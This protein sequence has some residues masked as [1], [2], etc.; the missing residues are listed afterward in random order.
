MSSATDDSP[1][2]SRLNFL[3]NKL[4]SYAEHVVPPDLPVEGRLVQMTGLTLVASGCQATVG[5]RCKVVLSKNREF[6]AEVI[7]FSD[8]NLYLMPI[9]RISGVKPGARVIPLPHYPEVGVGSSLL[10][11]VIDSQGNPIDGRAPLRYERHVPLLGPPI[12]PFFRLPIDQPLD[13]GVRAINALFSVGRGQRMGLFAGSGV[14]KSV[15]LG[16]MTKNTAA[17]VVV[18]AMIGERGREVREFIDNIL[19]LDS[20]GKAVVVATPAD[21]PPLMRL[22]GAWR[23]TAIAE[24]FRDQGLH[25][26]L[27]MDS[28][29]RFAQAQREL[30]LAIGEPPVTRGYPPSVFTQLPLLV[31]RA[32]NGLAET[33][34]SITAFYSVLAEADDQNDP[35]VD[36]TR[37]ILDGHIVLSRELAEIGVFP[38]VSVESSISR[39]MN[40]ITTPN[41]LSAAT[42]FKKLYSNYEK[43]RDLINVGAYR[44]GMDSEIDEAVQ[45]FPMLQNFIQQGQ[46]Q[47]ADYTNSLNT[48][49]TLLDHGEAPAE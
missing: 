40:S 25:V 31:E 21:D 9:G 30:S 41:H 5:S 47:K 18:V 49:L 33:G 32:G 12:N 23:A 29:T 26:L 37:A 8:G 14:G 44:A 11:R 39:V 1:T 19:G 2:K 20:I 28:L 36:A 7:G 45:Y 17:D 6:E 46:D 13:V 34:G 16:Q 22:H 38:A 10:G 15:L 24:Y 42:R 4:Q 3:Q 27:L 48:L 35:I 43:N